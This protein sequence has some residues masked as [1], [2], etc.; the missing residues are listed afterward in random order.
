MSIIQ[1]ISTKTLD[2]ITLITPLVVITIIGLVT[3]RDSGVNWDDRFDVEMVKNHLEY[4]LIG[5][6]LAPDTRNHGLIFNLLS[7]TLFQIKNYLSH[8]LFARPLYESLPID[9][10][11]HFLDSPSLLAR[12]EFRHTLVFLTSLLA[13]I[14]VAGIVTNIVSSRFSGLAVIILAL[15]PSWWGQTYFN[16]KDVPFASLFTVATCAGACLLD[17]YIHAEERQ[18]RNLTHLSIAYGIII[19]FVTGLRIAGC[20]LL[21][22]LLATH[23]ILIYPRWRQKTLA[24]LY[25]YRHQYGLLF[26]YWSLTTL[27]IYPASWYHSLTP[28]GWFWQAL[29]SLSKFQAWDLLVLFDGQNIPGKS[30]PWYY[31]PKTLWLTIPALF[32]FLFLIGVIGII[33]Q[34]SRF[35]ILQKASVILLGWQIFFLPL[36]AIARNSTLYDGMRH[37]LFIIPAIAAVVTIALVWIYQSLLGKF[38]KIAASVL[39]IISLSSIALD[40]IQLHPYQYL[41]YNRLSGGLAGAN[42]RYETDYWGLSIREAIEWLNQNGRSGSKIVVTGPLFA[43]EIFAD[44]QQNFQIES[45]ESFELGGKDIPDYFLALHRFDYPQK[46]P[47][48]AIAHQVQRQGVPLTTIKTCRPR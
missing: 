5:K 1:K 13:Y 19:G 9:R 23:F 27:I 10:S 38:L 18:D 30:L 26:L 15:F 7:E 32:S 22:F 41:Y 11:D 21:F 42:G 29:F 20:F 28:I 16:Q 6:N 25:S 37:F 24:V 3:V 8:Y 17:R 48:C 45:S 31:L 47:Q 36:L 35:S 39:L 33:L 4:V 43:S 40:S 34:F 46:F 14:G 2:K 44:P 12:L